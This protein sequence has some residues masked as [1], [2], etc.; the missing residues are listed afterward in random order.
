MENW[1]PRNYLG[2]WYFDPRE[3]LRARAQ[4]AA[5]QHE[6]HFTISVELATA[7]FNLREC[8]ETTISTH[9]EDGPLPNPLVLKC[10]K[11]ENHTHRHSNGHTTWERL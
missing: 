5:D 9:D 1:K 10:R 2:G 3:E 4:N 8:G 11:P 6:T 7:V